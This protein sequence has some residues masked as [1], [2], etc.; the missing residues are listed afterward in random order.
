MKTARKKGKRIMQI[1][2]ILVLIVIISM[3]IGTLLHET[4]FKKRKEQ[5]KPYGQLVAVND[6]Y[7]HLTTMGNGNQTIV[8]LPGM[9][10]GLPSADFAPL[11]R[12]LS[13]KYTVVTVEYFGVGFSSTTSMPRTTAQYVEEIRKALFAAGFKAPY[14]LMPHSISSVFSEYYAATY[15]TE[16]QAI[17][18]LDGTSTAFYAKMPAI[19]KKVLPIAS[20]QQAIG[21]TSILAVLTTNTKNLLSYGYTEK[22]IK[23]M[24]AFAGFSVNDT[25]L[26]QISESAEFVRQTKDL[27]FP[28]S[29][30]YFK[31]IS[32]K[33]YETINKQL[34]MSPQEYQRQHLERIGNQVPFEI[35]EGSHFIYL[36]N[37]ERIA[38]ITD[39]FLSERAIARR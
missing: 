1:F 32:K 9:G 7:M 37:V 21:T 13:E 35:L 38:E 23:D 17:I 24:V 8:L 19:V 28:S 12:K 36:N 27:P 34:P 4:F 39:E 11:M 15:P 5:I 30:P 20:F 22:E 10:V 6:G 31:I 14:V 25:L 26:E 3:L 2:G 18:S 16:V 33:T 29:I